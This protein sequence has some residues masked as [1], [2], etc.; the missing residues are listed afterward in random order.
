[1]SGTHPKARQVS[2]T[3]TA[4]ADVS[5]PCPFCYREGGSIVADFDPPGGDGFPKD[6]MGSLFHSM[7]P[8]E[9]YTRLSGDEF[10]RAVIAR[11]HLQ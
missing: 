7:P 3:V 6:A 8:C 1:M 10:I 4:K 11:R 9:T 5:G 2:A